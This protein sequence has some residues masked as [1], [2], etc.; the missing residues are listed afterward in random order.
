V[1]RFGIREMLSLRFIV[2]FESL[3]RVGEVA[4]RLALPPSLEGMHNVF[5]VS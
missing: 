3:E 4:Y 2:L 5:H 1:I